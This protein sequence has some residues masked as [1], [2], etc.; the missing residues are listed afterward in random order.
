M[1]II[2]ANVFLTSSK[3]S[4][5]DVT[6]AQQRLG[7]YHSGRRKTPYIEQGESGKK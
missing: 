3:D 6:L 5:Y 2:T 4:V 7:V 1:A